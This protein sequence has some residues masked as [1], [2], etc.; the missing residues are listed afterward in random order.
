MLCFR[1]TAELY[2][3]LRFLDY[4]TYRFELT[5]QMNPAQL[6][7]LIFRS[8]TR[9]YVTI[10]PSPLIA[11]VANSGMGYMTRGHGSNMTLEPARYSKDPDLDPS[12][13]Q[14]LMPLNRNVLRCPGTD[15]SLN[16]SAS[17]IAS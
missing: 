4:G 2:I 17:C 13:V 14:V 16:C 9:T 7:G 5:V 8:S 15:V 3:P 11:L 6:G 1:N 12:D 10:V